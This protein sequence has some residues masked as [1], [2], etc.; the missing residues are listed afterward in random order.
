MIKA[1]FAVLIL[2]ATT[3]HAGAQGVDTCLVYFDTIPTYAEGPPP[4]YPGTGNRWQPNH[5][6]DSVRVDTCSSSATY[7]E[8]YITHWIGVTFDSDILRIPA[9][10]VDS[11]VETTWEAIDTDYPSVR[12]GFSAI[13]AK[14]GSF[15]LRK[16]YPKSGIGGPGS[17]IFGVG[18]SSYLCLDSVLN[19]MGTIPLIDLSLDDGLITILAGVVLGAIPGMASGIRLFPDPAWGI[20]EISG[21]ELHDAL[22][23]DESGQRIRSWKLLNGSFD[24]S[25]FPSGHYFLFSNEGSSRFIIR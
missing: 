22:L 15:V 8:L 5:N 23:F 4:G 7:G 19:D 25:G 16:A 3:G 13:E 12:S 1:I 20:V 11:V 18:F 9:D 21:G 2:L 17:S 24:I 14:Y 6:P 10:S